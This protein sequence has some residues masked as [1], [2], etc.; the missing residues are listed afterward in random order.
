METQNICL[1]PP[2]PVGE[3]SNRCLQEEMLHLRAEIHQHLE[4]K[5]KAEVE[6][7]ELKA[8]IE[9]AGFSSV[10]HIR[11]VPTFPQTMSYHS[12]EPASALKALVLHQGHP[13]HRLHAFMLPYTL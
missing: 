8:Q 10:S 3:D 4:E 11:Y 1:Q 2:S 13:Q 7:K 5:R 9:E 6:L 12:Q